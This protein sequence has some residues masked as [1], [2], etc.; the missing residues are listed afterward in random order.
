MPRHERDDYEELPRRRQTSNAPLI[1]LAVAVIGLLIVMGLC[2]GLFFLARPSVNPMAQPAQVQ[3]EAAKQAA[4]AGKAATYSK[5]TVEQF[6]AEWKPNPAAS[7]AKYTTNGVELSGV[8]H[9]VESDP[10][11]QTWIDVRGQAR[12]N[13]TRT[14]ILVLS[15]RALEELQAVRVGGRVVVKARAEGSADA[16]PTLIAEEIRPTD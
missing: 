2:A 4:E 6:V 1:I 9:L 15:P 3:V 10:K 5:M 14:Q 13:D 11:K 16:T 12:D 7:A 8:L